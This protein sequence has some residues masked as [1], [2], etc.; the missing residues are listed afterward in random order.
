MTPQTLTF[1]RHYSNALPIADVTGDTLD[2]TGVYIAGALRKD[3]FSPNFNLDA[4]VRKTD[5]N[6]QELW[7]RQL[8]GAANITGIAAA[9]GGVYIAGQTGW[10]IDAQA[11]YSLPGQTPLG[12]TDAFIGRYNA[13]G[14]ELWTRQF[15]TANC[16]YIYGAV[17][18]ST[19]VYVV[20]NLGVV[21]PQTF[22]S[23][24]PFLTK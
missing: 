23:G 22:P 17:A 5:T 16:D 14:N 21:S 12:L 18:D 3:Q 6:G 2:S 1:V 20:G 13:N 9:S 24:Q 8:G 7:V 4:Y 11:Y 19:G 10:N 15:A